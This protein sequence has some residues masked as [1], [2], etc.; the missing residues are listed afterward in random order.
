MKTNAA[1]ALFAA[2]LDLFFLTSCILT[3]VWPLAVGL[4]VNHVLV[5]QKTVC[6]H[7]QPRLSL[8]L[9]TVKLFFKFISCV[10]HLDTRCTEIPPASELPVSV[11]A[12]MEM[13][14]PNITD[15][16]AAIL[17]DYQLYTGG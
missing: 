15:F 12:E 5:V 9:A 1:A 6:E 11:Y 16:R 8:N 14:K 4:H 7:R 13:M 3:T 17:L 10:F 2:L